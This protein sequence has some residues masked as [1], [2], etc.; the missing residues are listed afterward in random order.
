M[1]IAPAVLTVC[2]AAAAPSV[3]VAGM[4][5]AVEPTALHQA[6]QQLVQDGKFSGAVVIRHA[7]SVGFARGYGYA[8]PF[9]GRPFTPETPVD[10]ASLAKPVTAAMALLLAEDGRLDLDA[11]VRRYLAGYPHEHATVRH[12]LAHSAGLPADQQLEPLAG[13]TNE[14]LMDQVRTQ[15]LPPL[16]APGSEFAY[17]NACYT[18]LAHLIERVSGRHYLDQASLP[19]GV[20]I[21]PRRL[22]DWSGRAIGHRRT[23]EG[24]LEHADSYEDEVFYGSANLSVSATQLAQW[25]AEWWG[26]RLAEIHGDATLPVQIGAGVSGLTLGNWYCGAG[27]RRCHYLGHHEGF[28]HML[29]WDADRRLAVA[30][31]SN[32]TLPPALQQRL[33]RA[34]VAFAEGRPEDGR[35]ELAAELSDRAFSPGVYRVRSEDTITVRA[36][37]GQVVVERRGVSYPAY[38]LGPGLHYVPGLDIYL[39]SAEDGRLH[40]LSLYE[41]MFAERDPS[42]DLPPILR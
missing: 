20:A 41:E 36:G 6:L 29:Y 38:G 11:P 33:Q 12:L 4:A 40:L 9:T 27:G 22:A 17:C 1:R 13:K 10:S 32:N 34:L 8:D 2:L 30:M 37:E 24:G 31:V 7:D 14:A 35:A 23:V 39:T 18:T 5:H 19:S 26:P 15:R 16:F 3:A 21:R 28:H 25:G 42:P